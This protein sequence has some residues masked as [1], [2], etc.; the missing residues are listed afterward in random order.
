MRIRILMWALLL[1]AV[2]SCGNRTESSQNSVKVKEVLQVNNY[3]YLLVK[4][5]KGDLWIAAP[6]MEASPGETY[7]YQGGMIMENFY[8]KE[9]DRTF[10]QVLFVEGLF[11]PDGGEI[12]SMDQGMPSMGQETTPG[13]RVKAEKTSVNIS[14]VEGSVSIADLFA[15][16]KDYEGKVVRVTGEVTKFNPAIMDKNWVHLQDGTEFEGRFDLTATTSE[17]FEVGDQ[18]TLE[19]ILAT[20]Q[21]FGYGYAYEILLEK[22]ASVK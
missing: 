6:T 12:L 4:G 14:H 9:L 19:G 11:P 3:T 5:A 2:T 20:D 1:L 17:S 8:S 21:D 22:A 16:P 13:S 10:D 18:V 15:H 7:T